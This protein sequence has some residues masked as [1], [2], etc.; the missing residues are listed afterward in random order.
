[1]ITSAQVAEFGRP[2]SPINLAT[3]SARP[4]WADGNTASDVST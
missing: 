1:M 2:N 3:I 4:A